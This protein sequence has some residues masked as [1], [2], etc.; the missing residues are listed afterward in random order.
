[1]FD[2]KNTKDWQADGSN[3]YLLHD[4]PGGKSFAGIRTE[5]KFAIPITGNRLATTEAERC[6]VADK[7]AFALNHGSFN[8]GI[9]AA[10][11]FME[12]RS[13]EF[14]NNITAQAFAGIFREEAASIRKLAK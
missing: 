12:A 1:M 13:K 2:E 8:D 3:V 7:I 4:I 11:R 10:A 6:Q 14:P 5:I 9:E